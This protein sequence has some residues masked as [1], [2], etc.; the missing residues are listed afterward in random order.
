MAVEKDTI[1]TDLHTKQ[2]HEVLAGFRTNHRNT[3]AS[4]TQASIECSEFLM[5][6]ACEFIAPS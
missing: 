3:A 2:N 5:D 4:F 1:Q 6:L